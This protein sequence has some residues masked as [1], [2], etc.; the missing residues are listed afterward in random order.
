MSNITG[1]ENTTNEDLIK[2]A[3]IGN[4]GGLTEELGERL[5]KCVDALSEISNKVESL[6][7]K[8]EQAIQ[9]VAEKIETLSEEYEELINDIESH[10]NL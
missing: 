4:E 8:Y 7:Y 9:E 6:R 1:F 2:L 10:I 5:G 3:V